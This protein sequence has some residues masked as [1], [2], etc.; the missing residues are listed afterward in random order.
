MVFNI[1]GLYT[2]TNVESIELLAQRVGLTSESAYHL[3]ALVL[4]R[5]LA[6]KDA[7]EANQRAI[8]FVDRV[9]NAR[10]MARDAL[11]AF[12]S[13]DADPFTK[14]DFALR[15]LA[16]RTPWLVPT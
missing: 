3:T 12:L 15:S 8:A 4:L 5:M 13:R 2:P 14:I 1:D 16:A 6:T 9:A 7:L 10:G 11:I